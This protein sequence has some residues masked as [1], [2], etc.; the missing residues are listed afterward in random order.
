MLRALPSY[1]PQKQESPWNFC[2]RLKIPE[3]HCD[4]VDS[5][6]I[7]KYYFFFSFSASF[8]PQDTWNKDICPYATFQLPRDHHQSREN[9]VQKSS[10]QQQQQPEVA[11][12]EGQ[13]VTITLQHHGQLE[14]NF[15]QANDTYLHHHHHSH[16]A[17]VFLD[18]LFGATTETFKIKPSMSVCIHITYF[19]VG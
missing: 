3:A 5:L 16:Q 9:I 17:N 15:A 12:A 1:L 8:G 13:Q 18:P 7:E 11:S 19:T 10:A 4:L 6:S 14:E 2:S